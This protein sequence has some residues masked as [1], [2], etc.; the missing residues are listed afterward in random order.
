LWSVVKEP[1]KMA[2]TIEPNITDANSS[3]GN[4]FKGLGRRTRH[5]VRLDAYPARGFS[6]CSS[7]QVGL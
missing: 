5:P 4:I 6:K 3:M 2:I 7:V 1:G